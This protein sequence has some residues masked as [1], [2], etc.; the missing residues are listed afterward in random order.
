MMAVIIAGFFAPTTLESVTT[1]YNTYT[2]TQHIQN[3]RKVKMA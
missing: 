3:M 2:G 1:A